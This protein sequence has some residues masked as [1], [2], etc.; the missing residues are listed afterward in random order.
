MAVALIKLTLGTTILEFTPAQVSVIEY[1]S[2]SNDIR[3]ALVGGRTINFVTPSPTDAL[4]KLALLETAM[5]TGTGI[6]SIN[7]LNT[8]A[9]TTTTTGAPI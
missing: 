9:T 3:I 6:A 2:G 1:N 4:A 7:D 8:A 5:N